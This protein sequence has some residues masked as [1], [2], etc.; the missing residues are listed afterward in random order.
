MRYHRLSRLMNQ[1]VQTEK[2]FCGPPLLA[3]SQYCAE[4]ASLPSS[5]FIFSRTESGSRTGES[6]SPR[7]RRWTFVSDR[8]DLVDPGDGGEG[9]GLP[10]LGL[11]GHEAGKIIDMDAL[12]DDDDRAGAFVVETGQQSV[13]VPFVA[14]IAF[15][16]GIG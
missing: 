1:V 13:L 11:A 3:V 5:P 7:R 12:H 2:S 6:A 8:N 9:E 15:G 4:N 10:F 16:L 14:G